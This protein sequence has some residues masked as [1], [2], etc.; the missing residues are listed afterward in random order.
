M[1]DAETN[2]LEEN[3]DDQNMHDVLEN[4]ELNVDKP[5]VFKSFPRPYVIRKVLSENEVL[6]NTTSNLRV[7]V[8]ELECEWRWAK[9]MGKYLKTEKFMDYYMQRKKNISLWSKEIKLN[10]DLTNCNKNVNEPFTGIK[11]SIF[12]KT[13]EEPMET[14]EPALL[15]PI[16]EEDEDIYNLAIDKKNSREGDDQEVNEVRIVCIMYR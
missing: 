7:V 12:N 8:S 5:V 10:S 13:S 1:I 6:V 11:Q 15:I 4:D 2:H 3:K 9:P 14:D 16:G